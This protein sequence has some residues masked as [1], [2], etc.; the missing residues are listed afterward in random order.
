MPITN[1]RQNP[2]MSG[3]SMVKEQQMNYKKTEYYNAPSAML[4]KMQ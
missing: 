2:M 4:E 1:N 3:V